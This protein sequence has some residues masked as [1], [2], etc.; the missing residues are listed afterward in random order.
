MLA[1]VDLVLWCDS[2][3]RPVAYASRGLRPNE[4]N[5]SNY[6]SVK[7]EFLALKWAVTEKF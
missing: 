3:V 2:G 1:M 7:L 5:T 6:S 4:H